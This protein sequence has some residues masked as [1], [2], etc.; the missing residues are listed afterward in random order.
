MDYEEYQNWLKRQVNISNGIGL[1][2]WQVK[3]STY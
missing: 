1:K 2:D 3:Q